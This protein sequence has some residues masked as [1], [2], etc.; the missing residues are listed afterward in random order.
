MCHVGRRAGTGRRTLHGRRPGGG[1]DPIE[2]VFNNDIVGN[3]KGGNGII[4]GA[5]IR[6]YSEGPE[7][8]RRAHWRGSSSAGAAATC[9]RTRFADGAARPVRS[10]RRSFRVQRAPA[11]PRSASGSRARISR[12]S[13]TSATRSRA[14]RCPTWRRR[15]R[16]RGRRGDAGP[17]AAAAERAQRTQSGRDHRAPSGYDANLKWNAAQGAA[18]YRVFWREAWGM[19]WQQEVR[20][21][22]VTSLVLPNCRRR[23]RLRRRRD[24][25]PPRSFRHPPTVTPP[26]PATDIKTK[27]VVRKSRRDRRKRRQISAR[28]FPRPPAFS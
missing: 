24:R 2:A 27:P 17:G 20:V 25:A 3:D 6:V 16:E 4:D 21:G 23:L 15:A 14:S 28:R 19:D 26:R 11:S 7:D 12:A 1:K 18:A 22:N 10:R 8:S 5:T 13:T 9:R